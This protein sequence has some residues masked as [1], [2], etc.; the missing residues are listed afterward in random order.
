VFN[1]KGGQ[2]YTFM[3]L[4]SPFGSIAAAVMTDSVITAMFTPPY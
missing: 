2:S 3:L 1:V 4:C